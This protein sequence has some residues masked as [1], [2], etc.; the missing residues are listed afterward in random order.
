MKTHQTFSFAFVLLVS[1]GVARAQA[2]KPEPAPIVPTEKKDS[3]PVEGQGKAEE[4]AG[5]EKADKP[6]AAGKK[7]PEAKVPER[8]VVKSGDNPWTIAKAHGIPLPK[9]LSVN[10][11]KDAKNLKVGDILVLP[12][13]VE[14]KN[15][16]EPG[17]PP[18]AKPVA[19][20]PGGKPAPG[21]E[22]EWELYTIEPGDNPWKIAKEKG[23]DYQAILELN[24]GTD[25]RK[26]AV[27]QEIKIPKK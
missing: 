8:Y 5:G 25:F 2:P 1:I 20:G 24:K 27:G 18:V 21:G 3:P 17:P 26:L 23:L 7:E 15:P 9:L 6:E 14:S 22:K 13:G 19:A 12:E 11:I 16:P 4:S 10:E